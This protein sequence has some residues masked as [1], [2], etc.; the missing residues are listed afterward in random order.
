[1]ARA[2]EGPHEVKSMR[3]V[4]FEH[5]FHA[6]PRVFPHRPIYKLRGFVNANK[7]ELKLLI[8]LPL[9]A[10]K[11]SLTEHELNGKKKGF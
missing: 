2:C 6:L 7:P 1:M 8:F 5:S 3:C 10:L 11:C 4:G 9:L